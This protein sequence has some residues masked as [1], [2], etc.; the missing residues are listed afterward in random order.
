MQVKA[1]VAQPCQEW[2]ELSAPSA[3]E[4]SMSPLTIFLGKLI[5]IYC[6]IAALALMAARSVHP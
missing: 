2:Y 5:G 6:I 4:P 3:M 1:S